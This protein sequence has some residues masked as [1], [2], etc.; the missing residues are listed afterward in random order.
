MVNLTDWSRGKKGW[1]MGTRMGAG[2]GMNGKERGGKIW[3]KW[4]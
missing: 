1:W 2:G 3:W 4:E